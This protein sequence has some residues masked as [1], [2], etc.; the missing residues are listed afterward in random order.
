MTGAFAEIAGLTLRHIGRRVPAI[1]DLSFRW[2][3]GERLLLLGPS[4]S[5][6]STLALCLDGVIPHAVEA[7]WESGDVRVEGAATRAVGLAALSS[8]VGVVFQ[9]PETQLVMLEIDDEIAF[10]L[11]NHAVPREAMAATIA[12]ARAETGLTDVRAPIAALSGGTK[13]RVALA[14]ILALGPRGLVLDEPTANLDP[15]GAHEVLRAVARLVADRERSLLLIEHRLDDVLGLI[16]RVVVLDAEG[17]LALGGTPREVF[18]DGIERLAGLGVWVP[19]LR[20]L[21][22]LLGSDALPLD[23]AEAAALIVE[24]W[25]AGARGPAVAGRA[26]APVVRA[27]RVG[28]RYPASR[29]AALEDASLTIG[30]GELVA[31]VGPNGAGKSTLGLVLAGALEADSGS[32]ERLGRCAYVFQY[33][34]HQF[35]TRTVVD[36]VRVT[37]RARGLASA[38]IDRLALELLE[39]AGLAALAG[40]NPYTLSHGQK[41]RLSVATALAAEPEAL[42]LDEPTFGQDER[43]TDVLVETLDAL[44][45]EGRAIVAITHDLG[46]VAD[47]ATRAVALANGRIAFDGP[48]ADLFADDTLLARCALRRPPVAEAFRVAAARRPDV[49]A[50]IGLVGARDALR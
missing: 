46:L 40:A 45:A 19:Q 34:E 7:H 16:D 5:G 24:R 27:D 12:S 41:R 13:Q 33:P 43:T 38:A 17:R 6:K 28:Y 47:H 11:E 35:V 20:R 21:A 36:E 25:P 49:P 8:T 4:G 3:R 14:S 39:R 26:G 31:I 2:E 37:L 15:A 44:R 23:P 1:R 30:R 10:G 9:D 42:I 18:V 32:V 50:L 48:P 22:V 29:R